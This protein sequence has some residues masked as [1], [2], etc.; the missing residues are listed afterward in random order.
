MEYSKIEEIPAQSRTHFAFQAR[1]SRIEDGAGHLEKIMGKV[2]SASE[3]LFWSSKI[4]LSQNAII[5][6]FT[7]APFYPSP[8]RG[9]RFIYLLQL[10]QLEL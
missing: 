2:N 10:S 8:G 3:T 5:C 4:S 1:C 7:L 9:V 6:D